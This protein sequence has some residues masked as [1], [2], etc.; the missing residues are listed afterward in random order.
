MTQV[1]EIIEE[2]E[3][4]YGKYE[5]GKLYVTKNLCWRNY[6]ARDVFLIYL[7]P[8]P[9]QNTVDLKVLAPSYRFL[10]MLPDGPKTIL[11]YQYYIDPILETCCLEL[12]TIGKVLCYL[13]NIQI[14]EI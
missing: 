8:G 2:V 6:V 3:K 10:M 4:V 7:G 9:S 14:K 5:V 11:V 13:N 12:N 1:N